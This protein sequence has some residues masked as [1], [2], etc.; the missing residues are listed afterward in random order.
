MPYLCRLTVLLNR[1]IDLIIEIGQSRCARAKSGV[2]RVQ[3]HDCF[4]RT[5]CAVMYLGQMSQGPERVDYLTQAEEYREKIIEAAAEYDDEVMEAY[6]SEMPID[7]QKLLDAGF[8]F[9]FPTTV[10]IL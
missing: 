5:G 2:H 7:P 6:L 4:N 8:E 9:D 3:R 10:V 1:D